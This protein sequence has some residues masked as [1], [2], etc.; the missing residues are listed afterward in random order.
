MAIANP[1][2]VHI[3]EEV[4]NEIEDIPDLET[5]KSEIS[6]KKRRKKK[7]SGN[8]PVLIGK[9]IQYNLVSRTRLI[10]YTLLSRTRLIRTLFR[11]PS[12]PFNT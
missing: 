2:G 10:Q 7:K 11:S 6:K 12:K 1:G 3:P 5:E 9:Y 4:I 8:N